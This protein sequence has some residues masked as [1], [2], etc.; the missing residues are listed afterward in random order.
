MAPS[1]SQRGARAG[2]GSVA[3]QPC[4]LTSKGRQG[5]LGVWPLGKRTNLGMDGSLEKRLMV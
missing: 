1:V 3:G 5:S 2:R 4:P